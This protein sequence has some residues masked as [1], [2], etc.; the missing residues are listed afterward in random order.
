MNLA[1]RSAALI[2]I[3]GI[4]ACSEPE[5]GTPVSAVQVVKSPNP[6]PT[7]RL[8]PPGAAP[9]ILALWMNETSIPSGTN[10]YGRAI[11]TTNVASLEIRTESFSFVAQRVAYGD[12][13]FRQHV[14][15][16]VPYYKRP[17][18]LHVIARNTAGDEDELLVP[19]EF[20]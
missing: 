3:L 10:W 4:S 1:Y 16:M 19:I 13:R 11:T 8:A 12:F 14:L 18:T 5:T 20:R 6:W 17:Y 2:L 15:D 9:R 7:P